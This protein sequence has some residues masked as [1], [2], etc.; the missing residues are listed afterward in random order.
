MAVN[1]GLTNSSIHRLSNTWEQLGEKE[2]ALKEPI[3]ELIATASNSRNFREAMNNNYASG[4]N[5]SPYVGI[6]LRDLVFLDDGNPTFIDNKI[7][8][9]KC[10]QTYNIMFQIIRFQGRE[11]RINPNP[12][13]IKEIMSH[14]VIDEDSLYKMSLSVQARKTN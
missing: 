7:N 5:C 12:N 11:Y 10:I 9:L 1:A 13:I 2:M 4:K 14:K 6:Y 3:N 8:F